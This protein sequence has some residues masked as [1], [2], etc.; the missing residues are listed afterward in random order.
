MTVRVDLRSD[1]MTHPTDA[2]RRAMA[3][4]EVGDDRLGDDPTV[5]QLEYLDYMAAEL[6]GKQAAVYL[7]T[8]TLCTEI[9]L[10]V[11]IRPGHQVICDASAHMCTVVVRSDEALRHHSP[12]APSQVRVAGRRACRGDTRASSRRSACGRLW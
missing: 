8:G 10:R 11:L 7:P 1:T 5:N 4:T 12:H 6:T 9:A 3:A 2:M